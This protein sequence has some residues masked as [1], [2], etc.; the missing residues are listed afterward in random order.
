MKK[1]ND[2]PQDMWDTAEDLMEYSQSTSPGQVFDHFNLQEVIAR[3][4]MSVARSTYNEVA[5]TLLDYARNPNTVAGGFARMY[6][7]KAKQL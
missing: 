5:Q 2:I 4:L 6:A 3:G 1:P 7:E